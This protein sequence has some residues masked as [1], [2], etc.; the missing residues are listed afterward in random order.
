MISVICIYNTSCNCGISTIPIPPLTVSHSHSQIQPTMSAVPLDNLNHNE[1][2]ASQIRLHRQ[3]LHGGEPLSSRHTDYAA[4]TASY[5]G[6][7]NSLTAASEMHHGYLSGS[8]AQDDHYDSSDYRVCLM[9]KGVAVWVW[10]V[11]VACA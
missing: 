11:C 2:T 10:C 8:Q 6:S 1:F 4:S 9:M 7:N 3:Q 5:Y